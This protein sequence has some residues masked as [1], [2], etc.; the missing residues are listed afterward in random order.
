MRGIRGAVCAQ[1][2]TR[3]AIHRAT[4]HL[5]AEIVKRNKLTTG[6]IVAAFFTMTPDLDADFPAYAARDIGWTAIPML[7]AQESPVRGAP[8]RAI[9][10]LVLARGDEPARHVYLGR[11]AA[12]RPDLVEPGDAE[13]WNGATE[14]PR[15]GEGGGGPLGRLLVVGLGL[16]GGS[17]AAA[18]RA[19]GLFTVVTGHDRDADAADAAVRCGLVDETTAELGAGLA[20]AD[21]VVLAVPVSEIV[22]LLERV[23]EALRPGAVVTDVGSTKRSVVD[24]M[25][26]LP[27]HVRA[28]GGHP[29]TGSTAS[30]PRAARADLFRKAK[31]ALVASARTDEGAMA[32]VERLVRAVGARPVRVSAEVHDRVV[33]VTSHLPAVMAAALVQLAARLSDGVEDDSFLAGPGLRSASR[34]AAG[35][36]VMT[37]QMLGENADNLSLA[38]DELVEAL[39]ELREAVNG[40]PLALCDRLAEIGAARTALMEAVESSEAQE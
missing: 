14:E 37:A 12:M 6:E 28:V 26:G 13:S 33:A 2:N 21:M 29:M 18:A 19:S 30:G 16:I 11:A 8:E 17:L 39:S 36:P 34:L 22:N 7:G 24:A 4:Q 38:I 23:G 1:D 25:A 10:V 5:L 35:D 9:R 27:E 20:E 3:E 32:R 40:D 31:W 15:A